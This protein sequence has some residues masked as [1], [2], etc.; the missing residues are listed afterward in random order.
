MPSNPIPAF[1]ATFAGALERSGCRVD[2]RPAGRGLLWVT[3]GAACYHSLVVLPYAERSP[4]LRVHMDHY[5]ATT[6]GP[7]LTRLGLPRDA[8][9][10]PSNRLEFTCLPEEL[11][12]VAPWLAGIAVGD[13][14]RCCPVAL[15]PGAMPE[16]M[17]TAAGSD[18]H[19]AVYPPR[20]QKGAA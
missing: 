11:Q 20:A 3:P 5:V 16:Y 10:A 9:Q 17:W 8:Q 4:V 15:A 12:A 2:I 6:S 18:A 14:S 1:L 13:V 7:A 19:D